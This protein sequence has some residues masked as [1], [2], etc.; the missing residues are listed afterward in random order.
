MTTTNQQFDTGVLTR[1]KTKTKKP[2]QYKVLLH[3][4]DYTPMDFVV[5]ILTEIFHR[6]EPEAVQIML[7]VHKKGVG[8]AGI[9]PLQIA[10]T[11]VHK[12]HQLARSHKHPL[13]C[14]LEEV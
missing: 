6:S 4:D 2:S 9:Y 8:V 10:E 11:K 12:V 13:K 3:N 5:G 14:S 1:E 7:N